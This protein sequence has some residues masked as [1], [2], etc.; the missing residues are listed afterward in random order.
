MTDSHGRSS[1]ARNLALGVLA[2]IAFAAN[3]ILAR[4][5]LAEGGS[6][7]WSFTLIRLVSGALAL[8]MLAKFRVRNAGSWRG[9]ASLLVYVAGFSF[10]YLALGAGLG[11]LIL[12]AVVQFTMVGWALKSGE[13]LAPLQWAGLASAFAA[14][15]WL[16]SPSISTPSSGLAILSMIAAGLGWGAY[17]LIGRGSTS[18][19]RD[20]AGNFVRAS[21]MALPLS[22]LIF[23]LHPEALPGNTAI[24]AG[25][26]SGIITSGLGYAIWYAV[27]PQMGRAEAGILQLSVPAIAALGGVAFLSEP[28]T[29]RLALSA[30]IILVGVGLATLRKRS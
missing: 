25:L 21:L 24:A 19:T 3:S 30:T 29:F 7:A 18:P 14:L 23:W 10:A 8:A 26:A 17:S 13:H 9:A 20:T 1:T 28:L 2:M 22:P 4:Y 16:L 5:A 11:A 27:L 15:V 6:G 12:F